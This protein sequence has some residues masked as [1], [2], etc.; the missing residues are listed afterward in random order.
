MKGGYLIFSVN[1]CRREETANIIY[2]S[3][4]GGMKCYEE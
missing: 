2:F 1:E 4:S 3:K